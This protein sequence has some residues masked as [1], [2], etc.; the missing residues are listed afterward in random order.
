MAELTASGRFVGSRSE[1]NP[2][3]K[4]VE[5]F[6]LCNLTMNYTLLIHVLITYSLRSKISVGDL[7][8]TLY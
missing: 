2:V 7:V 5:P 8:Q 4:S 6:V 1:K 3:K